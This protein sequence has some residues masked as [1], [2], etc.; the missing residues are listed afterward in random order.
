MDAR[1][2]AMA[3]GSSMR[4]VETSIVNPSLMAK[5]GA[6]ARGSFVCNT[7]VRRT[8]DKEP[9]EG[10]RSW[11]AAECSS[12]ERVRHP[13]T[14]VAQRG[15]VYTGVHRSQKNAHMY[16]RSCTRRAP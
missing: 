8:F 15:F 2:V 12:G 4:A 3:W 5:S 10:A 6:G 13:A 16:C 1:K 14:F 9:E 11:T 7:P